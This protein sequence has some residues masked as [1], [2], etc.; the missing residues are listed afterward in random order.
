MQTKK[1]LVTHWRSIGCREKVG[2][3]MILKNRK[4]EGV[5]PKR[6]PNFARKKRSE[7]IEE[8]E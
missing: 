8:G 2:N 3:V 4:R 7:A 5:D 1:M 6:F